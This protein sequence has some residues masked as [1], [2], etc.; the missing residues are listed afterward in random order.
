[1]GGKQKKS[2][3]DTAILLTTEIE[4]N[5]RSKKKTSTLFLDVKGAFDHI[6]LTSW[7]LGSIC[8]YSTYAYKEQTKL[9]F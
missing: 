3:I 9:N 5:S 7:D 8:I 1:M 4:R 6:L 2:A